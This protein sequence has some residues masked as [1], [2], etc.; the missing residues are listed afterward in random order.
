MSAFEIDTG[1]ESAPLSTLR[2]RRPGVSSNL[3][4]REQRRAKLNEAR[5]IARDANKK[6]KEAKRKAINA[7]RDA[8]RARHRQDRHTRRAGKALKKYNKQTKKNPNLLHSAARA[9]GKA[10]QASAVATEHEQHA[11][12][13]VAEAGHLSGV[14][15][16]A[17]TDAGEA[18]LQKQEGDRAD[19][20]TRALERVRG[21]TDAAITSADLVAEQQRQKMKYGFH[22]QSGNEPGFLHKLTRRSWRRGFK[23]G[24]RSTRRRRRTK[25]R[26]RS[27]HRRR[28]TKRRRRRSKHRRRRRRTRR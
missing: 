19:V 8:A 27:K 2:A 26:R 9:M 3:T 22:T 1:A 7:T 24:G 28:R 11:P 17:A 23:R 21:R 13:L 12:T 16:M 25:R 5:S 18:R 14:A 10:Q 6:A 4:A 20:E 15:A